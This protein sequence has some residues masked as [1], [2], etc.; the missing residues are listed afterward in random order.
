MSPIFIVA[1]PVGTSVQLSGADEGVGGGFG[2]G[3]CAGA[4]QPY[5]VLAAEILLVETAHAPF[6][7]VH[8]LSAVQALES[9]I[10]EHLAALYPS[11]LPQ[12]EYE[13]Y[14]GF[15]LVVVEK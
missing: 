6:D 4:W 13:K 11:T 9:V 7:Q 3:V 10:A 1:T 2:V 12:V 15:P 8:S 5:L 14:R